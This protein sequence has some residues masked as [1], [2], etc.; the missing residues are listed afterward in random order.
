MPQFEATNPSYA[1]RVQESFDRQGLMALIGARVTRDLVVPVAPAVVAGLAPIIGRNVV[2]KPDRWSERLVALCG[3]V[4]E[5]MWPCLVELPCEPSVA[6]DDV[7]RI[8][9]LIRATAG[10]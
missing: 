3:P 5:R 8:A 6:L 1:Q 10:N 4:A 7:D 9:A 2:A